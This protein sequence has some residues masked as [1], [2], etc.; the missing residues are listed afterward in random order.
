MRRLFFGT[1]AAAHKPASPRANILLRL[2]CRLPGRLSRW[3]AMRANRGLLLTLLVLRQPPRGEGTLTRCRPTPWLT[4]G[5]LLL[6]KPAA[7]LLR[8]LHVSFF[9]FLWRK[10]LVTGSL[11]QQEEQEER[12]VHSLTPAWTPNSAKTSAAE[13]DTTPAVVQLVFSRQLLWWDALD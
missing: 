12:E 7:K 4:C 10:L 1:K 9:F 3:R 13:H 11:V 5:L 6:L 8:L 2:C